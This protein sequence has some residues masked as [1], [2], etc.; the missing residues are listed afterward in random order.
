MEVIA[1]MQASVISG[2]NDIDI[3]MTPSPPLYYDERRTIKLINFRN[4]IN[5]EFLKVLKC[6]KEENNDRN[7]NYGKRHKSSA[8]FVSSQC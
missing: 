2:V 8:E 7:F 3:S 6:V 4:I 5:W 1:A